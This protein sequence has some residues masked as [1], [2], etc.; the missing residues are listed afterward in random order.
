MVGGG[1]RQRRQRGRTERGGAREQHLLRKWQRQ[2]RPV[3]QQARRSGCPGLL[4][5]KSHC[6]NPRPFQDV[7]CP[8]V[9]YLCERT[10]IKMRK[11][12]ALSGLSCEPSRHLSRGNKIVSKGHP[13]T[14]LTCGGTFSDPLAVLPKDNGV[15][16]WATYSHGTVLRLRLG[17][18]VPAVM[19]EPR[20]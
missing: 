18:Q 20:L 12:L 8:R 17:R 1:V 10:E 13:G 14:L 4:R 11:R 3:S 2:S 16:R 15:T 6:N 19:D 9:P 5:L 7:R